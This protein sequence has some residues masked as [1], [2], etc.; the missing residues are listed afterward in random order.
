MTD[1][2]S[3]V[4]IFWGVP[5]G[6][7]FTLVTDATPLSVAEPYGDFLTH[8]RGHYE[9]WEAWRRLGG[10]GLTRRGLPAAIAFSEYEAFPRG[11]IVYDTKA[12]IFTIYADCKLQT[13]AFVEEITRAFGLSGKQCVVRS[14]AH[15]RS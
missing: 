13:A 10:T 2:E 9:V 6:F 1:A 12:E 14:D 11:R 15:Y 5:L 4:G 7:G 3:C 8:P